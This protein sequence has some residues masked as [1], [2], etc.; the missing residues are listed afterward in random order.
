V[1][2]AGDLLVILKPGALSATTAGAGTLAQATLDGGAPRELLERVWGADYAPDG[3]TFAVAYQ[4]REGGPFRLD[5]PLGTRLAESPG[6]PLSSVKV[7]PD[8]ERVAVVVNEPG[9]ASVRLLD[10]RGLDRE[11]YGTTRG[12]E[13]ELAWSPDGRRIYLMDGEVLVALG[14]D[15]GVH[16]LHADAA[17]S[18]V[19]HVSAAGRMLVEREVVRRITLARRDGQ[20]T[21][22]GW[23]D[24]TRLVDLSRDGAWAL[25]DESGGRLGPVGQPLLRRTDGGP[26]KLLE[27][28]VPLALSPDA[29]QV[30]IRRPGRPGRLRL[31]PIGAGAPRD[32]ALEGWDLFEGAFAPDGRRVY[33]TGRQGDGPTRILE[34]ALDGSPG[35][36]VGSKLARF[37]EITPDGRN[38]VALDDQRRILLAPVAGGPPV[39]AEGRMEDGDFFAGWSQ[40]GEVRVA[41]AEESARLRLD[42]LDL[43]T[44]KRTPWMTLAPP[45][46]SGAVRIR[47]ARA[48]ADGR[49]VAFTTGLVDV[50]DLLV[51]DGLK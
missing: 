7:S 41:H 1:S 18:T 11:L 26:P 47:A 48:S 25:M 19:H 22:L 29:Q 36:P 51:A 35:R 9:K 24:Y 5:Y 39:M 12:G 20:E 40:A 2:A 50:S 49:T 27:P 16:R 32:L 31:V 13:T 42:L 46:P 45:D 4:P 8:G 34:L 3:K 10:R 17:L 38:F 21:S 28:G 37:E 14:L 23:Q 6:A 44:G 43:R 30:L 33:A 15:G